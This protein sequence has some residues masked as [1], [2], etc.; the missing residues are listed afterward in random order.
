MSVKHYDWTA[1]HAGV[2]GSK[3]AIVDLDTQEEVTY[4][5]LDDR[6][7]RL[8]EWMQSKGV[9][10]GD[11]VAVLTPNCP[12]VFEVEFACS[13][14]GAICIPLNW[15]LTVPELQY[16]LGDSTPSLLI[17]DASFA[18]TAEQLIG[19]CHVSNHLQVDAEDA[20]S[21]YRQALQSV[22][23]QYQPVEC[24]HDDVAMIMYTSGTTG[25]PKGAMITFGMNFY[26]A[27][28]LGIPSNINADTV[29]LV[30]LP[31]FHTGG[32]NCYANPI[33]HAGG[34]ILLMRDFEPGRA[35]G[36]LGDPAL[37]VTHFFGVP[38]PYQFM[39]QHPDF[40]TTDLSRIVTA[41]V[42]GAPCAEAILLGWIDRGVPLIQG[43][44][45]TETSPGGTLLDAA[46]VMRKIGSAGKPLLHTQVKIIDDHGATLPWGEVGEL[47]IRGP[48]ITPGYWNKPEAT[49]DAFV[50]GWLKTG[51]AA[52]FDDE[53]FI[54]IVDRWKDMYI[55]GGENVYPAEVENVLYQLEQVAEAAIIGV[56]DDR[57][58]ETGK[59]VLVLKPG[60]TLDA[61]AVIAHCLANLAKFKVPASVEFIDALPRNATGKVLKRTLREQYVGANA[62]AIS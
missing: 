45:M 7:N 24:T 41:G 59:A 39:M 37:G 20:A 22:T 48:N 62:P 19:L 55:S 43:W 17:Y 30:V 61:D 34:R 44:G 56:P 35:L 46:D 23:G 15:R 14:V 38:A 25:H 1:Y 2:R 51:D 58:G 18:E 31:L 12:E 11:R 27:V 57:W 60:Q 40:P 4:G 28:N 3:V 53:G 36:V 33:L 29:Q 21:S 10:K 47:L 52:R 13:K 32:M 42:G 49:A 8:G 16:I 6:A 54:Y 5:T 26:N 9:V 50:D